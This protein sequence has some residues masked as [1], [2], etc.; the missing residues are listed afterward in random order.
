MSAILHECADKFC[1]HANRADTCARVHTWTNSKPEASKGSTDDLQ[2]GL[3]YLGL[4]PMLWQN[5]QKMSRRLWTSCSLFSAAFFFSASISAK[6]ACLGS[7]DIQSNRAKAKPNMK[8]LYVW[9][10]LMIFTADSV[11]LYPWDFS[12]IP[13]SE[14]ST[15]KVMKS[16]GNLTIILWIVGTLMEVIWKW[17]ALRFAQGLLVLLQTPLCLDASLRSAW[18]MLSHSHRSLGSL[19]GTASTLQAP[20]KSTQYT[21][22]LVSTWFH[23]VHPSP[24]LFRERSC[25]LHDW[26]IVI[27]LATILVHR[28][29]RCSSLCREALHFQQSPRSCGL[30]NGCA[31][32]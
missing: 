9:F 12:R 1:I 18:N 26:F 5:R 20:H 19:G 25:F 11:C 15:R 29:H 27:L 8:I 28:M 6:D 10:F 17:N 23:N 7:R 30:S 31:Q 16:E 4:I 3:A 24:V 21:K 32:L 14:S 13:F 22:I 2:I